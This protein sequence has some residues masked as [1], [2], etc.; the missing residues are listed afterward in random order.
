V[1]SDIP[2]DSP[3]TFH[4]KHGLPSVHFE[5]RDLAIL[6]SGT[7]RLNDI[8]INGGAALLQD[9]FAPP[10]DTHRCAIL[11]TFDLVRVRY[12]ASD[13]DLWRN[14]HKTKYWDKCIWILPI[15]RR[16]TEHWVI[17]I[18]SL[19]DHRILLFDSL[20]AERPWHRD[21]KVSLSIFYIHRCFVITHILGY[22]TPRRTN[23]SPS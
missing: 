5:V 19:K 7:A 16:T 6:K 12:R 4:R 13:E 15:H 1:E 21:V 22:H 8:C 10:N 9:H 2:D 14:I 11:S 3:R 18:V 23:D 20:A 17:G